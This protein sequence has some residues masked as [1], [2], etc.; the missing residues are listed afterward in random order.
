MGHF[1]KMSSQKR[2]WSTKMTVQ[3]RNKKLASGCNKKGCTCSKA[4]DIGKTFTLKALLE[5]LP[6]I[7][8]AKDKTLE[9]NP[10]LERKMTIHQSVEKILSCTLCK[11][12][13]IVQTTLEEFVF[14]K[15]IKLFNS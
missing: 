15:E 13:S 8:S 3:P 9:D 14:N 2:N 6:D 12:A 11:K 4:S 10:D 5:I 1:T 7:K